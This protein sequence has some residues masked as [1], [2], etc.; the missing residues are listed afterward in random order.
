MKTRQL[1]IIAV[2]VTLVILL[3]VVLTNAMQKE[4]AG[5]PKELPQ[6]LPKVA[7]LTVHPGQRQSELFITGRLAPRDR[8]ELFAEVGGTLQP[9][10]RPFKAGTYVPAGAPLVRID[11]RDDRLNL[12]AQ[13]NSFV[14]T[15]TQLLP[16]L[17]LDYP[18]AYPAYQ[19]YLDTFNAERALPPLPEPKTSQE[20]YFVT[21]RNL[22]TQYYT[23]KTQEVNLSKHTI[24]APFSGTIAS[25]NLDVGTLVRVGQPLGVFENTSTYELE[26]AVSLREVDFVKPGQVVTLSSPD[27]D[28]SWQ[29]RVVRISDVLDAGTQSV[30]IYIQLSGKGLRSG[31]YLEG[32]IKGPSYTNA[33]LL[34]RTA[35]IKGERNVYIVSNGMLRAT[36][37]SGLQNQG[38]SVLVQG[39]KDGQ[40]VIIRA[41]EELA[42]GIAVEAYTDSL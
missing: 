40:R 21:S 38:D 32:R 6:A 18:D 28:G 31:M 34:P 20:R 24:Y 39:L 2:G 33:A 10:G 26:A 11:D 9:I 41:A 22:Y 25:S 19:A 16:D 5:P 37:L 36:A 3:G 30:Q 29:G 35:L 15:L 13:K 7:Y 23:L 8:V 17:K 14:A 1:N 27:R 4:D 42:D 12:L